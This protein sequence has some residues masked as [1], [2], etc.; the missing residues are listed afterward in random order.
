MKNPLSVCVPAHVVFPNIKSDFLTLKSL[1]GDLSRTDALFWCARLNKIVTNTEGNRI[2]LQQRALDQFL[3]AEEIKAINDFVLKDQQGDVK[4]VTIFFRGQ[5]LELMRWILLFCQDH[6]NDGETFNDPNI[7]RKFAQ[8]L[9]IAGDL[10]LKRIFENR[11][12]LEGSIEEARERALGTIRKSIEGSTSCPDLERSFGRGWAIF[13]DN[14]HKFYPSFNDEFKAAVGFSSDEYFSC[15]LILAAYF[16]NPKIENTGI[17]NSKTF[18]DALPTKATFQKYLALEAQSIDNL[19]NLL[20]PVDQNVIEGDEFATPYN[21]LPLRQRPIVLVDDGRAIILD[22]SFF[23]EKAMVGP[24]FSL[25]KA[26][27]SEANKIFTAFGQAFEEYACDILKRTF[28]E[29]SASLDKQLI[30]KYNISCDEGEAEI[31]TCLNKD[32]VAVIFEIKAVWIREDKILTD[33]YTNYS[34]HLLE[35]Y[36]VSRTESGEDKIKGIGQL[37]RILK[38]INTESFAKKDV[39]FRQVKDIYPIL[40]VYDD[41]LT[42]PAYGNFL[43]AEFEKLLNSEYKLNFE[44]LKR[45][46]TKVHPLIVMNIEDLENLE[47]SIKHFDFCTLLSDYSNTCFDRLTSLNN[48]IAGSKYNKFMCRNKYLISKSLDLFNRTKSSIGTVV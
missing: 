32:G 10:W 31:D 46:G 6:H 22:A 17:F 47:C 35:K 30:F 23:N 33:D 3:I 2:A 29:E 12:S 25:I 45:R 14:F 44:E 28:C 16:N 27:P 42:A 26:N 7:R 21:Y 34:K 43:S 15:L 41:L 8:A 38:L 1:L 11:F 13:H 4:K 40:L 24:I 20:W 19:C 5:I 36:G 9:L 39:R 48:F 18:A 37:A